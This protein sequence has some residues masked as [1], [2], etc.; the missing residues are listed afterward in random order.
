[1]TRL[2]QAIGDAIRILNRIGPHLTVDTR[3]GCVSGTDG[4]TICHVERDQVATFL[5][6]PETLAALVR[7]ASRLQAIS[8]D[9]AEAVRDA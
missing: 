6:L 5:S 2:Q 1:M 7:A 9:V 8:V 3:D 4:H